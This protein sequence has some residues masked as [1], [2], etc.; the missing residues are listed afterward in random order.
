MEKACCFSWAQ[1]SSHNCYFNCSLIYM[2]IW[3]SDQESKNHML[4][5][6]LCSVTSEPVAFIACSLTGQS[7]VRLQRQTR[8]SR[9]CSLTRQ[10]RVR[11]QRQTRRS[12]VCSLTRQSRVRLQRQTRQSRVC[13]LTR[14]SRVRLR[15]QTLRQLC[16]EPDP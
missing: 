9:V 14:Q 10:S 8:Q 4:L 1:G 13:S 11:L 16:E 7:R 12:S 3:I 15:R 6:R 2:Y 5:F